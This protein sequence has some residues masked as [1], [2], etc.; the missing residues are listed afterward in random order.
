MA[1]RVVMLESDVSLRLKY[2][3]LLIDKGEGDIWIP[4]E[5][6][7]VIVVDNLKTNFTARL[8]S[9]LADY[10]ISMIICNLEHLPIGLFGAYD[11]HSRVSKIILTQI[12][13]DKEF[14]DSFW[15][16]I[17][18]KKIENQKKVLLKNDFSKEVIEKLDNW[19]KDV[20]DGDPTNREAHSAKVYFNTLM[21]A[22]FS[23][24]NEDILLNSGLDYGYAIIRG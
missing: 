3:N 20:D 12:N 17:I 23:R 19:S 4:L 11:N 2:N 7:S 16:Q 18:V 9:T 21:S 5:D 10:N 22:S 24:G 15:K 6:I 13:K 14:Y 1:Y 8:M